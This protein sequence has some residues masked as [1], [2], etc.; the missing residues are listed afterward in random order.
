[1]EFVRLAIHLAV[2]AVTCKPS[3]LAVSAALPP[4]PDWKESRCSFPI[5]SLDRGR[6]PRRAP[7]DRAAC[8]AANSSSSAAA[9]AAMLGLDTPGRPAHRAGARGAEAAQRRLDPAPG[10]H[11]LRRERAPHRRAHDRRPGARPGLAGLLSTPSWRPRATAAERALQEA[12]KDNAGKYLL[13]VTGSVP[14]EEN[15]IYT[16]DRRPDRQGDPGGGG[17]GRRRGDRDRRL[18]PLGQRAGGAAQSRPA[19]SG[20]RRSSRTSRW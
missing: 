2:S 1:M 8:P 17:E 20:S 15:G 3:D 13:V 19:P 9:L 4:A 6:D 12:M 16:H 14:L 11:R 7:R 10:M 18:R 5:P